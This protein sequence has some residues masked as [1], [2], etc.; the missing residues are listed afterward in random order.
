VKP[1]LRRMARSRHQDGRVEPRGSKWYGHYYI[2][3][4]REGEEVRKHKGVVLG[5][6]ARMKKWEAEQKLRGIIL[7]GGDVPK[8][9][10][11]VTLEW[12]IE[13]RFMPMKIG[14]W[15][16][17]TTR[18][19][20]IDFRC[21]IVPRLGDVELG[22]L[23]TFRCQKMLYDLAKENYAESLI[24]RVRTMLKA[25]LEMAVDME[26]LRKNPARKLAIPDCKVASK[27]VMPKDELRTLLTAIT[28]TRDHLIMM[29]GIFCAVRSSE[30]FGLKW[31]SHEDDHLTV[32]SVAWQHKLYDGKAKTRK[33]KDPIYI[34]AMIQYEI[35]QWRKLC[36]DT[37][38]DALMFPTENGTP[39]DARNF[40]RDCVRPVVKRLND[41]SAELAKERGEKP[42]PVMTAPLT[43][44]VWRRSAGTRNQKHGTMKDVQTLLRHETMNTTGDYYVQPI[45]ESVKQ[46]ME[47]DVADVLG[48]REVTTAKQ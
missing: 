7:A 48:I 13:N 24:K 9:D 15:R 38:P 11:A 26:F 25:A 40:I 23:D 33:A 32:R 4:K 16:K 42:K 44:Q 31:S 14:G 3:V 19:A 18:G 2:Y 20:R 36:P 22:K 6:K 1:I 29:I 37:S 17:A 21:Y 28:D 5:A 12:F 34:P 41:A 43:F 10:D 8:E 30:L 39:L 45:D 35:E 27:P 46:M 47:A